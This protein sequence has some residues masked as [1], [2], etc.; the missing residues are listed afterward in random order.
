MLSFEI[1][2]YQVSSQLQRFPGETR[3]SRTL[4]MTGPV[5]EHGIQNHALFAFNS[6]FDGI[7]PNPV[8]GYISYPGGYNGLT[9]VG[10]FPLSE[11]SYY[12]EILRA[13][14]PIQVIY[15]YT[16]AIPPNLTG[17][18]SMVGLGNSSGAQTG[19]GPSESMAAAMMNI[20]HI[21]PMPTERDL[22]E[23]KR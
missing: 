11:Y 14:K 6:F 15:D 1:D 17:Y 13:E 7:W 19:H 18:L 3:P 9:L 5:Q 10:W 4:D 21:L 23:R 16:G 20:A 22:P 8:A 2:T 12:Y